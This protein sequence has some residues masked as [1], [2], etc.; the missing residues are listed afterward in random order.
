MK[1][2]QIS[3]TFKDKLKETIGAIEEKTSVEVVVAITPRSDTYV[4]AHLKS[5]LLL[6]IPM[7]VFL[8]YSPLV[9]S[10][11]QA[12]LIL[13]LT[14]ISGVLLVGAL[15]PVKRLLV[16]D[17]RKSLYVKRAANTYFREHDLCETSQRSA[18]LLYV[19]VLEKKCCLLGD[20][21]VRTAVPDG[22]WRDMEV[23]F[24]KVFAS[25]DFL[26]GIL[27]TL[28]TVTETFAANLPPGETN[29]DELANEIGEDL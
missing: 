20:K 27:D 21:G 11:F 1:I 6:S 17:K 29:R 9:F 22:D 3:R 7:M 26:S 10:E 24:E 13:V 2:K 23:D 12:L 28:P 8:V 16:S 5:G 15:A 14:F 19:S 25:K 18:V 4:D